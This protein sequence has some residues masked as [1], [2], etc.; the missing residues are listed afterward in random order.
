M[1]TPNRKLQWAWI[2]SALLVGQGFSR[3]QAAEALD[4]VGEITRVCAGLEDNLESCLAQRS[5]QMSGNCSQFLGGMISLMQSP[6]GP[7]VCVADVQR[8]CPSIA[9]D[10]I[11]TC[12]ASK[13]TQFSRACQEY[14]QSSGGQL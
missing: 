7:T 4:C 11:S 6:S 13:R 9:A 1:F 12:I 8:L 2:F 10:A 3:A 14:L 5:Q